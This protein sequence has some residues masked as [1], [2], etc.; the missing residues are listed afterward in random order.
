MHYTAGGTYSITIKQRGLITNSGFEFYKKR[1]NDMDYSN[2]KNK[3]IFDFCESEDTVIDI[4]AAFTDVYTK[5]E[6][7]HLLKETPLANAYILL[8]YAESLHNE[9]LK[10]A[11]K[12][13]YKDD[14][15]AT[16]IT[17]DYSNLKNKTIFD[18]CDDT[19]FLKYYVGFTKEYLLESSAWNEHILFLY[20]SVTDNK[21]LLEAGK[22]QLS[23]CFSNVIID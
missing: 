20:A 1:T 9:N 19:F 16:L 12:E 15:V 17:T 13:Q 3:T 4:C 6:V 21:E 23:D 22:M 11:I 8:D 10:V 7:L 14:F 5:E 2:L 18:I